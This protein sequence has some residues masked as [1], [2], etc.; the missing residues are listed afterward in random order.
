MG[1]GKGEGEENEG[2]GEG[3][4]EGDKAEGEGGDG[5]RGGRYQAL[6]GSEELI[7]LDAARAAQMRIEL[8]KWQVS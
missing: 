5:R 3:E 8:G 6:V 1:E 4:G 2:N 7:P